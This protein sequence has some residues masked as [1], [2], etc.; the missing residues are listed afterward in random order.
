M[1]INLA[2]DMQ[3]YGERIMLQMQERTWRQTAGIE[4]SEIIPQ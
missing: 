3:G 2:I 4:V 1:G